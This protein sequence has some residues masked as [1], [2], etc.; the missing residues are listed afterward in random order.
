LFKRFVFLALKR[1][2]WRLPLEITTG[3]T[4]RVLP[5]KT[6]AIS[7]SLPGLP[8]ANPK[9]SALIARL[10]QH[11]FRGPPLLRPLLARPR[12]H[13]RV[14]STMRTQE[15]IHPAAVVVRRQ[16]TNAQG[17]GRASRA[18]QH[19]RAGATLASPRLSESSNNDT[20]SL[21]KQSFFFFVFLSLRLARPWPSSRSPR[22]LAAHLQIWG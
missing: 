15:E 6:L 21:S 13:E 1:S 22:Y 8:T 7:L 10:D 16:R 14:R 12:R 9:Q 5:P 3:L 19:S 11:Y 17:G 4:F 2:G 18:P 20:H